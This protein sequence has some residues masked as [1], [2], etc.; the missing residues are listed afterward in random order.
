MPQHDLLP[1]VPADELSG[2]TK[3]VTAWL[4]GSVGMVEL[5]NSSQD[6]Y[7]NEAVADVLYQII[8]TQAGMKEDRDIIKTVMFDHEKVTDFGIVSASTA[9]TL[10]DGTKWLAGNPNIMPA[11][12]LIT[13]QFDDDFGDLAQDDQP[14]IINVIFLASQTNDTAEFL[15]ILGHAPENYKYVFCLFG[16]IYDVGNVP[17]AY[18]VAAEQNPKNIQIVNCNGIKIAEIRDA[19]LSLIN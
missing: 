10:F 2:R 6:I 16:R 12:R 4:D 7:I 1:M 14:V 9:E 18:H 11:W 15:E 13:H 19:I 5:F 8:L 3:Y 17:S